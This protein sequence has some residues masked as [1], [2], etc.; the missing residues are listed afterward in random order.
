MKKILSVMVIAA[1]LTGCVAYQSRS[2]PFLAPQDNATS[3]KVNG[4]SVGAEAFADPAKA[5]DAFGFDVRSA[6]L[7]PIQLVLD[8]QSGQGVEV[9]AAQTFL[10]DSNNRYWKVLTQGEAIGRVDTAT[11]G[12]AIG[13]GAG[14]GAMYGAA[15][16]SILGLALGVVSGHRAGSAAITGGVL[17]AAGGAVIGGA[18][19]A[20]DREERARIAGD[21]REKV[22]EGKAI[23]AGS[24]ASGFIFFPGEAQS[25]KAL[26][27]QI[28]FRSSGVQQILLLP[29]TPGESPRILPESTVRPTPADG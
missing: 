6:G 29:F 10:I 4:L 28:R 5:D 13:S 27:L 16:G 17:G 24:L 15:A 12:G 9:M 1:H 2:V 19:K 23:P 26:R 22:I 14:K 25:A 7:L 3:L 21:V 20:D 18:S 8:N 11:A